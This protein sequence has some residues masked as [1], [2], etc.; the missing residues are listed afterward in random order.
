MPTATS[1]PNDAEIVGDGST[2][3]L[4]RRDYPKGS[5]FFVYIS[6]VVPDGQ[7]HACPLQALQAD[8][9]ELRERRRLTEGGAIHHYWQSRS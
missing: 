5:R 8:A 4:A 1:W 2:C 9:V 6:D 3:R 7:E